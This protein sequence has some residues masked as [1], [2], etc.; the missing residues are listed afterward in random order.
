MFAT[1]TLTVLTA[2]PFTILEPFSIPHRQSTSEKDLIFFFGLRKLPTVLLFSWEPG[3]KIKLANKLA[4]NVVPK[5]AGILSLMLDCL[6]ELPTN[7]AIGSKTS[8][9]PCPTMVDAP[10]SNDPT[11]RSHLILWRSFTNWALLSPDFYLD[12]DGSRYGLHF[13]RS[14]KNV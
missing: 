3:R 14:L 11:K 9:N 6:S 5:T 2:A 1:Q 13:I 10:T 4:A 12:T 8:L 7:P